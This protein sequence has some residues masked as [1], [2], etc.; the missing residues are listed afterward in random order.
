ME[1]IELA[2][3]AAEV[4]QRF[5][6]LVGSYSMEGPESSDLLLPSV[7]YRRPELLVAVF[8]DQ[9]RDH[10]GRRIDVSISLTAAHIS[11]AGLPGLV[12]G[13][14]SLQHIMSPGR[15]TRSQSRNT[16][17]ITTQPGCAG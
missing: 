12:E 16:P 10:P 11:R 8:L 15:P 9:N 5:E 4:V 3:F 2:R 1:R 7:F 14:D 17:W 6:F 13:R